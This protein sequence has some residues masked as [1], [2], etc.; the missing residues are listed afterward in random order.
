MLQF[1]CV[2]I[3]I[4]LNMYIL[5]IAHVEN[6]TVEN[7]TVANCTRWN[8]HMLQFLR[9][10][11]CPCCLIF[12]GHITCISHVYPSLIR[13]KS[14][15]YL[16]YI[17]GSTSDRSWIYFLQIPRMS[18]KYLSY[19]LGIYLVIGTYLVYLRYISNIY[20]VY[21]TFI[22]QV[23]LTFISQVYLTFIY[24]E[25]FRYISSLY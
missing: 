24:Q 19:F 20:Q 18:P 14:Q 11:I 15:A 9:V 22:S 2:A 5:Q 25:L 4:C 16:V 21:L 3:C 13:S 10:T 23:Y 6:C 17:I 7:C 12:L 8:L 1:L